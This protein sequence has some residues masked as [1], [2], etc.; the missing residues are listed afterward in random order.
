MRHRRLGVAVRLCALLE[1]LVG[2]GLVS[3]ELLPARIVGFR[4]SQVRLRLHHICARLVERVLERPLVDREKQIALFDELPVLE[5]QLVEITRYTRAHLHRIDG[6]ET[7]DIF[8]IIEDG[9]L[10]RLRYGHRRWWWPTTLLLPLSA[11]RNESRNH[12]R[13]RKSCDVTHQ[14][15]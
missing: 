9:A 13:Q 4:E 15:K 10:D 12:E 5:M 3:H 1:S 6:G 2:D 7:P 11:A 8:V 14:E